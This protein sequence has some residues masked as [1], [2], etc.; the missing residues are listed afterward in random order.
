MIMVSACLLGINCK[1]NGGSNYNEKV[2]ELLKKG[3][4]LVP[5]CPE[6]LG[7][8]P[9]PREPAEI[10]NGDG[11]EVI[12][13]NARV[14]TKTGSDV[15]QEFLKG[16]QETL[17]IAKLLNIKTAILKAKSP[18]CGKGYIYDGSFSHK[19]KNGD[20]V[21]VALLRKN[22]IKVFSEDEIDNIKF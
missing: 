4:F 13:G 17:K 14:V 21:T 2:I 15:T 3:I 20:G 18:S 1:Y 16:A 19:L 22:G 9:T 8:L 12:I 6:Q 11:K 10:I 5:V 7:G